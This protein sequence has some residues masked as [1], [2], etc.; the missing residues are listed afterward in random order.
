MAEY[1]DATERLDSGGQGRAV[2]TRG[3]V[4]FGERDARLLHEIAE[5]GSINRA[6]A[7]LGRSQARSL[8]RIETL[9]AEFGRLVERTRGGTGGGGSRLTQRG[10]AVLDRYH[11]VASAIDATARIDE[12]VLHGTVVHVSGEL[13]DVR[14]GIG[15]VRGVHEGLE[16]GMLVQ[17]RIPSDALTLHDSTETVDPDSTSAR[18][19]RRGVVCD[20]ERGETVHTIRV[21]VDGAT[22]NATITQ[23]SLQRLGVYSGDEVVMTWKATATRLIESLR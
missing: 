23:E 21:K 17:A 13:A 14:T 20:I 10:R 4:Q 2:L 11:R 16:V 22:C 18:N 3:D 9:E 19:Q 1:N 7:I 8:R 12:T 5:H 15:P 6:A